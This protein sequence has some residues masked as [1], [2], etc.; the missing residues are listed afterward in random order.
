[1][2]LISFVD[3]VKTLVT[4]KRPVYPLFSSITF[5]TDGVLVFNHVSPIVRILHQRSK[6]NTPFDVFE[7][8]LLNSDHVMISR[9]IPSKIH[10][11]V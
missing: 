2:P 8:H 10:D 3:S 5:Y 1:M 6:H 7:S 4:L 11:D 9:Y